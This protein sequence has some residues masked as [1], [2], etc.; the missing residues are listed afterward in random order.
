MKILA[1]LK[2]S[3]CFSALIATS[4]FSQS[5]P[6]NKYFDSAGVR[7]RYIELGSGEPVIAIHG[8]GGNSEFWLKTISTLATSHRL[9]L[10]DL[11]GHGLSD[12]PHTAAE[13][14][15]EMGHDV[16]RLMDHLNIPK[17]HILG[18]SIG[19]TPIGMLI[20]EH[21]SRF[22]S[23]VFGG[24]AARWEWGDAS[25]LLNQNIYERIIN[26]TR[27]QQLKGSTKDQDQIAIASLRLGEKQ[28]LVSTQSLS[29]LSI[30]ILAIVGSEDTVLE[31]VENFKHSFPEIELVVVEGETHSSL[32]A[33]PK[34]LESIEDF[35]LRNPDN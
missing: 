6:E 5:P 16:I 13:Y 25:D 2:L 15:R 20:T 19:V 3:L 9:I 29:K 23:A 32:P 35:L 17:A 11:R 12:K 24:G 33:H 18:Y 7:I 26:S 8:L 28:L 34:F 27:Q 22:I 1:T 14:G 31:A 21:E 4:A 30:P 10:F